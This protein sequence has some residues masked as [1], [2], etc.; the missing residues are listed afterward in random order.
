MLQRGN[1]VWAEPCPSKI[2]KIHFKLKG[3][4]EQRPNRG[5]KSRL[6]WEVRHWLWSVGALLWGQPGARGC[7]WNTG[8][9]HT[10]GCSCSGH[11]ESG[12]SPFAKVLSVYTEAAMITDIYLKTLFVST[13]A[14]GNPA[15]QRCILGSEE[16][17]PGPAEAAVKQWSCGCGL[18]RQ[19]TEGRGICMPEHAC[20][21]T[22]HACASFT[23]SYLFL[24]L[25]ALFFPKNPKM[26]WWVQK[27]AEQ[28]RK[29]WLPTQKRRSPA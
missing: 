27:H 13:L 1:G 17:K 24:S 7:K 23:C 28:V 22:R 18:Q 21:R 2:G 16:G 14:E 12:N 9:L 3:N 26:Q 8:I 19:C 6:W 11:A 10:G 5:R 4:C 15:C 20:A 25:L 29:Q